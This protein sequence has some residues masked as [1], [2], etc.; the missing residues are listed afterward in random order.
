MVLCR[1]CSP[2]WKRFLRKNS[3]M[4]HLKIVPKRPL[5]NTS[6]RMCLGFLQKK[7]APSVKECDTGLFLRQLRFMSCLLELRP[8]VLSTF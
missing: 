2:T 8:E 7:K 3:S 5:G 1:R 4:R 6:E